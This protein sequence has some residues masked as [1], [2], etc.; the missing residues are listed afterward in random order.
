LAKLNLGCLIL[1]ASLWERTGLG[2][3]ED[4]DGPSDGFLMDLGLIFDPKFDL[5]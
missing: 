3:E 5:L 1:E 4:F 2:R